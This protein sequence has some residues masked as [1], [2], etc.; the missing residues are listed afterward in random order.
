MLVIGGTLFIGAH[1]VRQIASYRH[2]V[3]I[4]HPGFTP[5][6]LVPTAR[7]IRDSRSVMP[8][9]YFLSELFEFGPNVVILMVTMARLTL[10]PPSKHRSFSHSQHSRNVSRKRCSSRAT[11]HTLTKPGRLRIR[12]RKIVAFTIAKGAH[13]AYRRSAQNSK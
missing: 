6:A 2:S 3:A 9:L 7:E 8:I 13:I 10:A 4:Y 11:A 5:A 12:G 1:I